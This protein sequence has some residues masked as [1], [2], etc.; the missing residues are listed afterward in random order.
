[1]TAAVPAALIDTPGPA[2]VAVLLGA[3]LS[4]SLVFNVAAPLPAVSPAGI[5]NAA[6]SSRSIAPGSLIS[7]YGS[8]LAKV[9]S[10]ASV[11]PL[12]VSLNGTSVS[13]NGRPAPLLFVSRSQINA[14]VPFEALSGDARMVVAVNGQESSPA[15]FDVIPT[16]PGIFTVLGENHALAVNV[17]D[18]TPNSSGHPAQPGEYVT[19]FLTGQGLLDNPVA[20]G[21]AAGTSPLSRPLAT[22]AVAIGGQP[23]EIQFAGLAPG[24]VGLLQ[25]N[26]KVPDISSGEQSLTV[27]IGDISA[28]PAVLSISPR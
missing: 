2:T 4:G 3:T 10:S 19:I 25:I 18:G 23:A 6:S 15:A 28:V 27:S 24:F 11:V 21:A 9:D 17:T 14:L 16:A 12:P 20:T 8:N 5:V 26:L 13:I 22:V 1:L 7:I